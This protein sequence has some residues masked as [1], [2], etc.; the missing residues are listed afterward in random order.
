MEWEVRE[1]DLCVCGRWDGG[2]QV[3][4]NVHSVLYLSRSGEVEG[5]SPAD[6]CLVRL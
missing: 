2:A 3:S 5:R 1:E 4:V 6:H